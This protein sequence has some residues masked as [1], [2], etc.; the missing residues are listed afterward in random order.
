[1]KTEDHVTESITSGGAG[2]APLALGLDKKHVGPTPRET[3][4]QGAVP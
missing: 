3:P 1:M 2:Q 4:P